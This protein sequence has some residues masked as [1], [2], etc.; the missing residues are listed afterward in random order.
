MKIQDVYNEC[1]DYFDALVE[2]FE[3]VYSQIHPQIGLLPSLVAENGKPNI[4]PGL[5]KISMNDYFSVV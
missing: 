3:E 1:C 5:N 4:K 2:L